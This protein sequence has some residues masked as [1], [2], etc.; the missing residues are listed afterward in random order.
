MSVSTVLEFTQRL[1]TETCATCG[2]LFAM[3][4]NMMTACRENPSKWFYCP[5]GH[6]QHYGTSE[7]TRLKRQL[8]AKEKALEN[9]SRREAWLR[10]EKEQVER[11]LSAT[12]GVVTRMKRRAGAGTCPACKRTFKQV[13]RHMQSQHP[14]YCAD[15]KG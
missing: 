14:D 5:S 10:E 15:E 13:A 7:A 4:A 9:A 1:S 8:E 6:E 11:S 12:R 2:V 3:P